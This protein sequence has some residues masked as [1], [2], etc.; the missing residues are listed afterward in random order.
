MII[1]LFLGLKTIKEVFREE[2]SVC[3]C[4]ELYYE[5]SEIGKE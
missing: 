3:D 1:S 5:M 2:L 4:D